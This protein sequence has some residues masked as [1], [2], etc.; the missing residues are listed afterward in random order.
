MKDARAKRGLKLKVE[1]LGN[2]PAEQHL[3]PMGLVCPRVMSHPRK[4][5]ITSNLSTGFSQFGGL[6]L[7]MGMA[8]MLGYADGVCVDQYTTGFILAVGSG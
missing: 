6:S 7:I 5:H 3:Q 8:F 4:I 1:L 2:T